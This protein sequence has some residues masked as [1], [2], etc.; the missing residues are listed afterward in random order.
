MNR[1]AERNERRRKTLIFSS[2]F[3][4]FG[5]P[6]AFMF[7]MREPHSTPSLTFPGLPKAEIRIALERVLTNDC[8][9]NLT[10]R[11]QLAPP[12]TTRKNRSG[13]FAGID[14][15]KTAS[16]RASAWMPPTEVQF[17]GASASVASTR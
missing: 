17:G 2:L 12:S 1:I 13:V 14:V 5:Q 16:P 11:P 9:T 15:T 7:A 4:L 8:E 3:V 10:S 6:P